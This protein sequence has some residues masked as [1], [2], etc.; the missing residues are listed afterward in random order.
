MIIGLP[1]AA[2]TFKLI[3]HVLGTGDI[4]V[5]NAFTPGSADLPLMPR[6]GVR[7]QLP[8]E[9]RNVEYYGTGPHENY[10]DR[11]SGSM[12]GVY[13]MP[14]DDFYF[15]YPS[16]QENGN[17]TDVRWLTLTNQDGLGLLIVGLP[18]M[19]ATVSEYSLQ[20]LTRKQRGD[21]HVHQVQKEGGICVNIDHIQMG[22]GGDDS[23]G[24]RPHT[25]YLVEPQEYN[26]QF[27][28]RPLEMDDDP[29]SLSNHEYILR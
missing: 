17:R 11:N 5:S 19:E 16:P 27:R 14:V 23:W 25:E 8:A 9:Y 2:G 4:I 6:V 22:V 28:L 18:M 1:N 3:Y 12:V 15:L 26:F 21:L 13:S 7:F 20:E 29:A 10:R 24:A